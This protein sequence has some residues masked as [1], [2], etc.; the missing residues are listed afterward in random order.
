FDRFNIGLTGDFRNLIIKDTG[1]P[2]YV[3]NPRKFLDLTPGAKLNQFFDSDLKTLFETGTNKLDLTVNG[4]IWTGGRERDPNRPGAFRLA[5]TNPADTKIYVYE[6]GLNGILNPS[7]NEQG[8]S[9]GKQV[10]GGDGVFNDA[11]RQSGG[12]AD[13]GA[14]N[15]IEQQINAALNRG[16]A[17]LDS[18]QWLI[19]ANQYQ[20]GDYNQYA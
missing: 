6:P 19:Y 5:F 7:W 8:E 15:D 12:V 2:M 4:V 1:K 10:F 14:L 20:S 9:S 18:S 16:V 17:N 3:A 11:G 13:V